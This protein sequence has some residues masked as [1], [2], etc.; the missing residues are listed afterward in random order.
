MLG[1]DGVAGVLGVDPDELI[2][3][4]TVAG[5]TL[6]LNGEVNVTTVGPV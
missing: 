2:T 6:P 3:E 4:P 1:V 5:V